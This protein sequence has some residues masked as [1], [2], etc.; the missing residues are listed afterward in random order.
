MTDRPQTSSNLRDDGDIA[1]WCD[2]LDCSEQEL[3]RAIAE[4]GQ[5]AAALA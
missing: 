2:R 5:S 1:S 4:V 3:P